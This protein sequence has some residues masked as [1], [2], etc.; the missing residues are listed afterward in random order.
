MCACVGMPVCLMPLPTKT[1]KDMPSPH[2][3]NWYIDDFES[4][5]LAKLQ[6]HKG[7]AHLSLPTCS[8]PERFLSG[9]G[10]LPLPGQQNSPYR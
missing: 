1:A 4:K 6:F 3:T 5:T 2:M 7:L 10:S 8:R 9:R